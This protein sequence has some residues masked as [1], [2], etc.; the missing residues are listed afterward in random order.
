MSPT[1]AQLGVP[2]RGLVAVCVERCRRGLWLMD[3]RKGLLGDVCVWFCASSPAG[4]RL[5]NPRHGLV[6]GFWWFRGGPG[7]GAMLRLGGRA[8]G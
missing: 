1:G 7:R 2:R 8:G 4:A 6:A 3:S 5:G